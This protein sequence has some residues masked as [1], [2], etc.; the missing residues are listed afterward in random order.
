M[1]SRALQK[2]LSLP[3]GTRCDASYRVSINVVVRAPLSR[4]W[5]WLQT[6]VARCLGL[7]SRRY[8]L[9]VAD[10]TIIVWKTEDLSSQGLGML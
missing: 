8:Q 1:P 5:M 9:L 3:R 2:A 6:V 7:H 4:A 10:R